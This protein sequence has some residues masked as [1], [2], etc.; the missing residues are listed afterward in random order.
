ML[1]RT[2]LANARTSHC[3]RGNARRGNRRE[4]ISNGCS[5]WT[6]ARL[7]W[8]FAVSAG[9]FVAAPA[10][11]Q[12]KS[13]VYDGQQVQLGINPAQLAVRY[14]PAATAEDRRQFSE[15]ADLAGSTLRLAV[16]ENQLE[17]YDL[18]AP[19]SPQATAGVIE[20]LWQ[21][22]GAA[23]VSPVFV[24]PD[25]I[26]QIATGELFVQLRAD[27]PADAINALLTEYALR[28]VEKNDWRAG[29]YRLTLTAVSTADSLALS[30]S[31]AQ[32]PEVQFCTPNFVR[33]LK[34]ARTPNDSLF[35]SQWA[36][37]SAD[38]IDCDGPEAWEIGRGAGAIAIL[39]DGV[40][41]GHPELASKI[42]ASRDM[43]QNDNDPTPNSWDGHGTA[44]AG[45]AAALS[46]NGAGI[47]GVS[48]FGSLIAVRVAQKASAGDNFWTTND[49]WLSGGIAWAYQNGADVLSNSWGGGTP[50]DQIRAAIE[51][52]TIDGRG[53]LGS[54]VVFA[55]GN[56]SQNSVSFPAMFEAAIA[57][58]ATDRSDSKAGFSNFG[59]GVD[60][61]AP[62]VDIPATDIRGIGGYCPGSGNCSGFNYMLDFSGTSAACPIVAGLASL[63]IGKY[64]AYTADEIRAR[65]E[66][67]CDQVG[68]YGYS[69]VTGKSFELG[70]GRVNFYRAMSGKPQVKLGPL[71][72]NPS[73]FRDSSD[74]PPANGYSVAHHDNSASEWLGQEFSP[75]RSNVDADDPDGK[76]NN[77][78]KDGFDDGVQF[79]LP[80]VPGA[81]GIVTV[82]MSVEDWTSQRYAGIPLHLNVWFDWQSDGT[83]NLTHDWVLQN[84][85]VFPAAWGSNTQT[86]SFGFPVPDFAIGWHVQSGADSR[87]L[88]VR[89]R[90]S[91]NAPLA[92]ATVTTPFGEVEDHR[93][94]NFVE[95]FDLGRG[96]LTVQSLGCEDWRW[97]DALPGTIDQFTCHPSGF[98]MDGGG[99]NGY[100][101]AEV[102]HQ[103]APG[104]SSFLRTP[105][106]DLSELSEAFLQFEFSAVEPVTG[107]VQLYKNGVLNAVLRFYPQAP[108]ALCGVFNELIDL[109]PWCGEGN[110][111]I[112]IEF[113]TLDELCTPFEYQ[114]WKIDNV[115]IFGR[116]A[117]APDATVMNVQPTSPATADVTWISPGDDAQLYT[118]ELFN[119]RYGP[120]PIDPTNWRHALWLRKNMVGSLPTPG[121]PGTAH[122]VNVAGLSAGLHFFGVQTL[123]EVTN[124]SAMAGAGVNQPPVQTAPSPHTIR[125]GNTLT[126]NVTASD[127]EFDPVRMGA[128]ALP[129]GAEYTETGPGMAEFEWRPNAFQTGNNS[130]VLIARD[131]NGLT[132]MDVVAIQVLAPL[133]QDC[134]GNGAPDFAD[135]RFGGVPD[136][137]GNVI[138]DSC[139][140]AGGA[141]PD[142]NGN[143]QP[144]VC[145]PRGQPGDMNCDGIVTVSDIGPF[146]L[147]LTNPAA[148]GSQFPNCNV[149][150]GDMNGDGIVSVSDIG[151]FV[152]AL[153]HRP[154][155]F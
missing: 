139:D 22:A 146:V 115:F 13:I 66:Q 76:P 27:A 59:T 83:F 101:S 135:I 92:N 17:V 68:G 110:N 12:S 2:P 34:A 91:Y 108:L 35:G 32:R 52:A 120:K 98:R 39:D 149:F 49:A 69:S 36:A 75:E 123:D 148:Y 87:F 84:V 61:A 11:A 154:G 88:H 55:A 38:D 72:T 25:G 136:C 6:A 73:S 97:L 126:F 107:Q 144:D 81:P 105:R 9:F 19:L 5:E 29:N 122:T 62:G 43:V 54:V 142:Y 30:V 134:N 94:L 131:P 147:A 82:T 45:I 153:T 111:D 77:G 99:T 47:A 33:R 106:F 85:P 18:A 23:H 100:M 71:P 132:D 56:D 80:Y 125:A 44:C 95:M 138:P 65:I 8:L 41:I 102:Y 21:K 31:I 124:I 150:N 109:T 119:L 4:C 42:I 117:I 145:D 7:L 104:Y 137:N 151:P 133:P 46:D 67:T 48:W 37:N 15:S 70:F 114:D 128:S 93:V 16:P 40:D 113:H 86:V 96:F 1:I 63:V 14:T 24:A 152:A 130:V 118:A 116:D 50:S 141:A 79:A 51:S 140:I 127:P 57:V 28:V 155:P 129:A 90:L 112:R 20:R 10:L 74:A 26:E 53:G 60:L 64:P 3:R 143:G 121:A 58:A 89:A 78:H 103:V